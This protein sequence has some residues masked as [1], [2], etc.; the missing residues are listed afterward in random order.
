MDAVAPAVAH[1]ATPA[2][3]ADAAAPAASKDSKAPVIGTLQVFLERDFPKKG[4][5][6]KK[7]VVKFLTALPDK[8]HKIYGH[9][10]VTADGEITISGKKVPGFLNVMRWMRMPAFGS[11]WM[12]G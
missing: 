2:P 11:T 3:A 10:L 4:E 1:P 12:P 9:R 8:W 7:S 6:G 5:V